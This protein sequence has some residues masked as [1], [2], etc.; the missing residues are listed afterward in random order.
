LE[1]EA[2]KYV[3]KAGCGAGLGKEGVKVEV[4]TKRLQTPYQEC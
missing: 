3:F 4:I 1:A 2:A